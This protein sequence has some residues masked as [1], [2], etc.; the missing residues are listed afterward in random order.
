VTINASTYTPGVKQVIHV[1]VAHPEAARWGFQ[2]TARLVSDETQQAGTLDGDDIVHV[3]CDDGSKAP[4]AAPHTQ[5]VEHTSAPRTAAGVGF[6]FDIQWTP[7]ATDVGDIVFYAAGNAANGDGT[8]NGD[9]IYTTTRRISPPCGLTVKPTVTAMSNGASFQSAWNGGGLISIFGKDFA[10][11]GK[12]RAAAAGDIVSAKFPQSLGCVAV[13]VNGQNASVFYVQQDQINV[14]APALSGTGPASIVVIANP[15]APNELRS[16]AMTVNTQQALAPA[17]FTFNGK[18]VAATTADGSGL[19]ADPAVVPKAVPAK[20]G[21]IITIY[22]TGLGP[23][24]PAYAPGEIAQAAAPL[25]G[26]LTITVG[27]VT[28]PASDVLYAGAVPQA[29]CG[30]QQINVKLP[31]SLPDGDAPILLAIGGAQSPA[32]TTV[33]VKK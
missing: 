11:A 21:D 32:G 27:G 30:L 26:T 18:S 6:T 33:P 22:A 14:Q 8:F 24:N 17:M 28:V 13:T 1:T 3:I 5:F 2:L 9:R 4:C 12:T 23:M 7:P 15:G 29:I 25:T 16:D 20:P 10:P 19:I 31:A